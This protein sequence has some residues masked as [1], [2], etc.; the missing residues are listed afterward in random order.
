MKNKFNYIYDIYIKKRNE[1]KIKLQIQKKDINQKIYFLDNT[2]GEISIGIKYKENGEPQI[3]KGKYHHDFLKELNKSNVELYINNKK[4]K[5]EKYFIPD[6]VRDYN[7]LLKFNILMKDCSFMFYNCHNI[8]DLDLSSFSTEN[9]TNMSNMF[10]GCSKLTNLDLSSF[11]TQKVT[12]MASMFYKCTNLLNINLSSINTKN[13]TNMSYLFGGCNNLTN[14]DLSSFN[15]QNVNNMSYMFG[16]CFKLRNIDLSSFNTQNVNNMSYMFYECF[17]MSN[18]DLSSFNT[19]KVTY[20]SDLFYGCSSLNKIKVKV[21]FNEKI[22]N[23]I[24]Q[25]ITKIEFCE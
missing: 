12:K 9:V 8:I 22:I 1:I 17:N 16:R 11:N 20:I 15:T 2:D 4:H 10:Y 6:E 25:D 13:V 3:I 7:I 21:K 24:N 14:L 5:F 18:I 19:Q 23:H